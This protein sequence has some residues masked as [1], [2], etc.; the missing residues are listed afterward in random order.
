MINTELLASRAEA[1]LRTTS[2]ISGET[3]RSWHDLAPE[4]Q[5]AFLRAMTF[6]CGEEHNYETTDI[7]VTRPA[8]RMA[9]SRLMLLKLRLNTPDPRWSSD[10]LGRY[11]RAVLAVPG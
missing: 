6:I 11:V 7:T 2:R 1:E 9:A 5:A 3:C 8:D 4:G 10:V